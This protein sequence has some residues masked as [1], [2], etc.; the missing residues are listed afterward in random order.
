MIAIFLRYKM[1][2][3]P[4]YRQLYNSR[5]EDFVA[6]TINYFVF[7][8]IYDEKGKA[9]DLQYLEVNHAAEKLVGKKREQLIGKSRKELFGSQNDGYEENFD[10]VVK[11][12]KTIHLEGY[13]SGLKRFYD[14]YAWKISDSQV[15]VVVTDI[16]E[17][18]KAEKALM[19]SEE[20][21]RGTMDNMLEGCQIIGHDWRYIYINKAAERHNRRPKEELLG[22]RYMDIWPGIEKTKVFEVISRC[23]NESLCENLE[24]YF[25]F[26]DGVSG[27]FELRIQSIPE[28]I[29][30][31][32]I[33]I[34]ERKKTEEA[35]KESEA[36]FSAAFHANSTAAVIT[37][38]SDGCYVDVNT[39]FL[40]MFGFTRQEVIGHTS[41]ELNIYVMPNGRKKFLSLVESNKAKNVE[42]QFRAKNG[43]IIDTI[44][45]TQTITLQGQDHIVTTMV[46]ITE[47][48]K[49]EEAI[50]KQASLIDLSPDAIIVK[51][52]EDVITF[53]SQGAKTLYGWTKKEAIGQKS[54]ELFQTQFP[55]PYKNILA[56][57]KS[58]GYWSGEKKHIT[59]YGRQIFVQSRWLAKRDSDGKI[60]E[61]LE[62][63]E[64]ITSRKM[65]EE[66]LKERTE[67]LERTQKKL[68]ENACM[69]EEYANQMEELAKQRLEKL[70]DSERLAAI[71]ATAGM[72]GHDIR[73]PLQSI[74]GD[75]YLARASAA[76]L[77]ESEDK[78]TIIESLEETEKSID[79]IN[80]IVQDLQD[81]A[82]PLNPK[83][84]DSYLEQ[85]I[86]K[87]IAKNSVPDNID[88]SVEIAE[89]ASKIIA[90]AYY[91]NR[92]L[93]NLVTNAIQ[94]MPNGGKLTIRAYREAEDTVIAVEDSGVGIP[95]SV[96]EK[97]FTLMFTTKSK[98]QGF[99]LPV[100]KRMAE[101][102]G[103]TVTFESQEGKGTE[104]IVRLPIQKK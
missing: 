40:R 60:I 75:L 61:L 72:V 93:Y 34:T 45:S 36:K 13:G 22:K 18:K 8:L 31:L 83:N 58:K 23:L 39:A 77:P 53:W 86:E 101:S 88:V 89:E 14:T 98:G 99:G 44:I 94:A 96:Q 29:F 41:L 55:E 65:T 30:I 32:S 51:D 19:E 49:A 52:T 48:K 68:E 17:R 79:Y 12:G 9:V 66:A 10:R 3:Q 46:D 102:L 59:K 64:D 16:T 2:K 73:N 92:I 82:R 15:G 95:Q 57:L 33:D 90:D 80:K 35:I 76:N 28:G 74:T 24:N 54:R 6:R 97:M 91:L 1:D 85:I 26:P 67:Q 11:S 104:F 103:G 84:E 21:F 100:V 7:E 70:K 25:V 42:M 43:S 87:I 78:A 27:W 37:R 5:L 71:G 38:W 63:N 69:L 62:T 50:Q 56:E 4:D 47:R 20:R 81:Y